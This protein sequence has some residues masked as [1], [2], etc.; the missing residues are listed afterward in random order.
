MTGQGSVQRY[1]EVVI[2]YSACCFVND[3]DSARLE[4]G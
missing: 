3:D 1:D 2:A 4:Q